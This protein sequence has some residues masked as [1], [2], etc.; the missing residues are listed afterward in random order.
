MAAALCIQRPDPTFDDDD[1]DPLRFFSSCKSCRFIQTHRDFARAPREVPSTEF[2][3][4]G[5]QL[6]INLPEKECKLKKYH[7]F[8]AVANGLS[9]HGVLP[10]EKMSPPRCSRILGRSK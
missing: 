7:A 9:C 10:Q 2:F 4:R 8:V 5:L 6:W 1:F 3:A